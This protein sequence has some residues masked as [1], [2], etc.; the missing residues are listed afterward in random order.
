VRT[1]LH[2][3]VRFSFQS[4][5]NGLTIL[6]SRSR[7][8]QVF[9]DANI[10][11]AALNRLEALAVALPLLKST[12][13]VEA[14]VPGR[15]MP[16]VYKSCCARY[17]TVHILHSLS[18]PYC[19]QPNLA[20]TSFD[21]SPQ[22]QF[23]LPPVTTTPTPTAGAVAAHDA[24]HSLALQLYRLVLYVSLDQRLPFPTQRLDD[25]ITPR[26]VCVFAL[27]FQPFCF[28]PL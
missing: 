2:C 1:R 5:T 6:Q 21:S 12:P 11:A 17:A 9:S 27:F 14:R 8:P 7:S 15:Q 28:S 23:P 18:A 13:D 19:A 25:A 26:S 10:R 16:G 22:F 20:P 3:G 24:L 4:L